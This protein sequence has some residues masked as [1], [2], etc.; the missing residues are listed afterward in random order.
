MGN[1]AAIPRFRPISASIHH[2]HP[3]ITHPTNCT[4]TNAH[5]IPNAARVSPHSAPNWLTAEIPLAPRV[6][7]GAGPGVDGFAET[8]AAVGVVRVCGDDGEGDGC[9]G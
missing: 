1:S 9:Y 4:T 7:P 8:G 2:P 6:G 5:M 3:A